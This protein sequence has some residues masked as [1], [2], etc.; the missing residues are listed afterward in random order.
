MAMTL[1]A[2]NPDSTD[3]ANV[4]FK[5][6]ID[7]TY[8]L[9]IFKFLNVAPAT[10]NVGFRCFGSSDTGDNYGINK[11][12][13]S[14]RCKHNEDNSALDFGYV[15]GYDKPADDAEAMWL[16]YGVGN[17]SDESCSG[18]MWLFN[19]S[20]TTYVTHFYTRFNFYGA[21]DESTDFFQGGYWN[22]T[23]VVDALKF[24]M[25]SGNMD[26][27]IKMYGVG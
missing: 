11:V 20:N 25:D 1:L 27:T 8:K 23:A 4:E 17:G 21:S 2:T 12:T 14:W 7:N 13:T 6:S 9:Y 26:G 3:V 16:S 15:T 5:A 19:P 18:T 22:V 10:D 24:Q